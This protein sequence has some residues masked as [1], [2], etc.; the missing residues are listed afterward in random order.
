[1]VHELLSNRPS[2][3]YSFM[4]GYIQA[5]NTAHN[6]Q[7][8]LHC[9]WTA[10]PPFFR[11]LSVLFLLFF[12]LLSA[13]SFQASQANRPSPL[14]T[15][16]LQGAGG[17]EEAKEGSKRFEEQGLPTLRVSDGRLM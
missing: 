17:L 13:F 10:F 3:P 6:S 12:Q 16:L 8:A 14:A 5:H 1:M 7:N 4:M 2:D 15:P 11:S 9:C